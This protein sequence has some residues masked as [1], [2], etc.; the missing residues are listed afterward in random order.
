MK[1]SIARLSL[2][3]VIAG[4]FM[5]AP[6]FAAA[7]QAPL[8]TTPTASPAT[9]S[10]SVGD[11]TYRCIYPAGSLNGAPNICTVEQRLSKQEADKKDVPIGG[12]IL[13]KATPDTVKMPIASRP[14]R[15]TLMTPLGLSL[16]KPA[17]LVADANAPLTLAWQSCIP[18]GCLSVLELTEQQSRALRHGK[19]GHMQIN[20]LLDGVLTIN[21]ALDGLDGALAA[22]EQLMARPASH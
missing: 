9:V 13:A 18:T 12:V 17:H 8:P 4:A 10:G 14:W 6:G 1:R 3:S 16:V 21:F 11:W 20:K 15:L 2:L 19:Q 5:A 22:A 7:E